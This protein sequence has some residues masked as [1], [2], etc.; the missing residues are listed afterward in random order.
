MDWLAAIVA[1]AL[2]LLAGGGYLIRRWFER[3]G[4]DEELERG[5]KA[6][7][8]KRAMD[9]AGLDHATLRSFTAG[10]SSRT[11]EVRHREDR[12]AESLAAA[13]ALEPSTQAEMNAVQQSR[14]EHAARVL[15]RLTVEFADELERDE[16]FLLSKA[17]DAWEALVEHHAKI[18]QLM[19]RDGSMAPLAYWAERER[20][21]VTRIAELQMLIDE[22]RALAGGRD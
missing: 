17:M 10:I 15:N 18:S 4:I 14:A 16:A 20:M 21:T 11:A 19:F 7:S 1:I 6:V 12:V 8:L 22:R 2:V 9:E 3:R 13:D 5:L